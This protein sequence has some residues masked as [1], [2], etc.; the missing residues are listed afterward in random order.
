MASTHPTRE[1]IGGDATGTV[2][3]RFYAELNDLLPPQWRG[4]DVDHAFASGQTV[5]DL[6]EAMGVPHTEIDLVLVDGSS[7]AF[8]H[9]L[10]DGERVSVYPV[11]EALDI[12]P[13]SQVRP[14]PLRTTR[15]VADVHLGRLARYLR[16]LGFD[17]LYHKEWNDTDLAD[18][19]TQERRIL[20]TRDRG[21]LKRAAVDHGYLVR[22]TE[23]RGQLAEVVERFDLARSLRPFTRCPVC[24]GL[25]E[26]VKKAEVLPRLPPLTAQHYREFWRCPQCGRLY[27]KGGHYRS[28]EGLVSSAGNASDP[29]NAS[30]VAREGE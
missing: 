5:K 23:P 30:S 19:A 2:R 22:R 26:P 8:G 3:I 25:V 17:T 10:S 1:S 13:V 18:R 24:N 9:Q 21:L 20:L 28:L 29:G 7:V 27:W 16:I 6:V 15:F 14:R 12:T 11:F 4:R